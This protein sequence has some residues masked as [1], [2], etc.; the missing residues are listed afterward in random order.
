MVVGFGGKFVD[1]AQN[2]RE[3]INN[4]PKETKDTEVLDVDFTKIDAIVAEEL[5]SMSK[6]SSEIKEIRSK[7][8]QKSISMKDH[9]I[10]DEYFKNLLSVD[11]TIFR[12][13]V[14][15]KL[16]NA[17]QTNVNM[18]AKEYVNHYAKALS[19][20]EEVYGVTVSEDEVTQYIDAHIVN[21]KSEE[22]EAY[23][24]AL[25]LTSAELDYRFDRDIYVMDTLWNKLIPV[26][27]KKY[28]QK[29]NEEENGYLERIKSEFYNQQ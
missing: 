16:S 11:K 10:D 8:N 17:N 1:G 9:M 24:K 26:L 29:E 21:V 25:G 3:M 7:P 18:L 14:E 5:K 12:L 27:M 2:E 28:P 15:N 6:V 19:I 4:K 20:A 22:K 23:A 13:N